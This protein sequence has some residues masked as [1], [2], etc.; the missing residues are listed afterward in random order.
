[1]YEGE[2]GDGRGTDERHNRPPSGAVP[3]TAK[4]LTFVKSQI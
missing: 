4:S 3:P 1:M 2:T